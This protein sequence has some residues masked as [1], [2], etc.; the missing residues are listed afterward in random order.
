MPA[1]KLGRYMTSDVFLARANAAVKKAVSNLEAKGIEPAYVVREPKEAA[2]EV[3]GEVV[4]V[5]VVASSTKR[6]TLKIA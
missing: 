4:K 1:D 5:S 6:K 3:S 2:K